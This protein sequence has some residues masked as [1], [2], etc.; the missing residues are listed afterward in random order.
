[1]STPLNLVSHYNFPNNSSLFV[2]IGFLLLGSLVQGPPLVDTSNYF[3]SYVLY[4]TFDTYVNHCTLVFK[5]PPV[6]TFYDEHTTSNF[7]P[8]NKNCEAQLYF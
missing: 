7:S 4:K 8:E 6:D 3:L 5:Q 1:M 2:S